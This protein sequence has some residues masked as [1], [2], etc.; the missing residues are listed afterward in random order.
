MRKGT[1]HKTTSYVFFVLPSGKMRQDTN[2]VLG[3]PIGST[4]TSL[5]IWRVVTYCS[6]SWHEDDPRSLEAMTNCAPTF[7]FIMI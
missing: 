6:V 3:A 7:A 2:A 1:G 5:L 4:H